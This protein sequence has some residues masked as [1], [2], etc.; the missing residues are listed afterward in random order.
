MTCC[1]R[2]HHYCL[3]PDTSIH[4]LP[5]VSSENFRSKHDGLLQSGNQDRAAPRVRSCRGQ[6]GR[7]RPARDRARQTPRSTS[8]SMSRASRSA[9]AELRPG[10]ND[11]P[12]ADWHVPDIE[13]KLAEVTAAGDTKEPPRD[14][15]GDACGDCHLPG[16]QRARAARDRE[17]GHERRPAVACGGRR[18]CR[19]SYPRG[20]ATSPAST[21]RPTS[22]ADWSARLDVG[23][24]GTVDVAV[25]VV[26]ADRRS[27]RLAEHGK[28]RFDARESS[29]APRVSTS[30]W[31]SSCSKPC[32]SMKATASRSGTTP[33]SRRARRR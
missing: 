4:G 17:Q 24:D 8:A 23:V 12:A 16:R 22:Q 31:I 11:S 10:G 7:R 20:R 13:A 3:D 30:S 32:E 15:G 9:R 19:R 14:V 27:H 5:F 2:G 25:H 33:V 28:H 18:R 6:A 26:G 21:S 1:C 29:A